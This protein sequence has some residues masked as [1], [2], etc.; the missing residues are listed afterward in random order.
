MPRGT[1]EQAADLQAERL[2]S[3]LPRIREGVEGV[4]TAPGV[5]AAQKQ[6]KMLANLTESI[7]NGTWAR[8][9]AAVSLEDWKTAMI[10]KGINRIASGIDAARAKQV[11]FYTHLFAY[12]DGLQKKV[13]AMRDLTLEDNIARMTEWVRG[14]ADCQKPA[15]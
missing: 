10:E 1:P 13:H 11:A 8:N 14:M 5:L 12:Q 4:S 3:S 7:T 9:V 15:G 6:D 2:K